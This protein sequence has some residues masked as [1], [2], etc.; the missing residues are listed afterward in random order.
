MTTFDREAS[1]RRIR[2]SPQLSA[3][4]IVDVQE[5]LAAA[6]PADVMKS[7][8]ANIERLVTAAT[9]LRVPIFVSEQNPEKLGKTLEPIERCL[10]AAGD[11]KVPVRRWSKME[12][13]AVAAEGFVGLDIPRDGVRPAHDQWLVCGMEAHVCIYQTVRD[14]TGWG[15]TVHLI[16]DAVCSRVKQNYRVGVSLARDVGAAITSTEVAIFDLL[17]QAG[18]PEFRTLSKVIK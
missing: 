5:K 16:S 15:G 17:G 18:T 1:G 9:T 13:S 11:A 12:F 14:I 3:L 4:L 7:V 10:T 2:L 6:M 8:T